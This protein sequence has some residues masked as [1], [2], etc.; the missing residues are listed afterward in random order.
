MKHVAHARYT[1]NHR[2]I[3]EIFSEAVVPDA[4]SVVNT[5]RVQVSVELLYNAVSFVWIR[6][7]QTKVALAFAIF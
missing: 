4:R 2:L 7:T 5:G 3:N 6:I 1:R